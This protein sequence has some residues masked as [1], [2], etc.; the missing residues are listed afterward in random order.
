LQWTADCY[1]CFVMLVSFSGKIPR[2]IPSSAE[3]PILRNMDYY[4]FGI[5]CHSTKKHCIYYLGSYFLAGRYGSRRFSSGNRVKKS[6]ME[7]N[8]PLEFQGTR[9]LSMS[10]VIN[11]TVLLPSRAYLFYN[12]TLN[13]SIFHSVHSLQP[14]WKRGHDICRGFA[15]SGGCATRSRC[16]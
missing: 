14:P 4:D 13:L 9:N 11:T 10:F 5:P 6:I 7:S 16:R 8:P 12:L 15:E 1:V 2:G 3:Y